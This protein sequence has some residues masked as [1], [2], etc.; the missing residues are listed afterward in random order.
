M[1]YLVFYIF[2]HGVQHQYE[3]LFFLRDIRDK[4]QTIEKIDSEICFRLVDEEVSVLF[5]SLQLEL[6]L[7]VN[8]FLLN[9][10][11]NALV[12]FVLS[13]TTDPF[14]IRIDNIVMMSTSWSLIDPCLNTC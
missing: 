6:A 14:N 3:N 10:P 12:A 11:V 8:E 13:V 7:E 9:A 2:N 5:V 1:N 4:N